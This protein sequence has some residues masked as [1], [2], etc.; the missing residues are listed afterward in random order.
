MSQIAALRAIVI[1]WVEK[2]LAARPLCGCRPVQ[3]CW[4]ALYM[5]CGQLAALLAV[6]GRILLSLRPVVGNA[7]RVRQGCRGWRGGSLGG[8]CPAFAAARLLAVGSTA[9]ARLGLKD[10]KLTMQSSRRRNRLL[11]QTGHSGRRGLL[12]R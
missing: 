11:A 5:A 9:H 2:Q 4:A 10:E 6:G 1:L 8:G 3:A 7:G 12:R